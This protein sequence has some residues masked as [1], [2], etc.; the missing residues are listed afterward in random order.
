MDHQSKLSGV[1][2]PVVTPFQGDIMALDDL[3][4]NLRQLAKTPL[5]GYLALGSNG[6]FMS[7]SEDEQIEVLEVFAEEKGD[8]T[9]MVGTA[10]ES[11]F[12][13]IAFSNRVAR[14]GFDYVSVLTPH[15]FAKQMDQEKLAG[16]YLDIADNVDCPVLLYNAPKFTGG[17]RLMPDTVLRLAEHPNI[18]G[19]KD[20]SAEG[21]SQFLVKMAGD[22]DFFVL[23]GGIS[24]FYP[25]LHLGAVGGIVSL[26]NILPEACC[27]LYELFVQ[28][29][30]RDAEFLHF[31][32][33]RLNKSISGTH[34][35]AGVK[36]A[37]N[38]KGFR[39]GDPRRPLLPLTKE[40]IEDIEDALE[41]EGF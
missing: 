15:Y 6:E 1:F 41:M 9:V 20:S 39:G 16:F 5:T 14:M 11:T 37:M 27:E 19:I 3:R 4:H 29:R 33:S 13:T 31:K 24:T 2:A 22:E 32:L 18:L 38:L 35:V 40:E 28:G 30:P 7:L 12:R 25:S 23:S 21:P 26:A 36:A 34:G 8:K 10:R 17:V